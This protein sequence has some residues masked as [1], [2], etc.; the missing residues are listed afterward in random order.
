MRYSRVFASL[1][2]HL[3]GTASNMSRCSMVVAAVS[4]LLR[5]HVQSHIAYHAIVQHLHV[6]SNLWLTQ[7]K[8]ARLESLDLPLQ[9]CKDRLAVC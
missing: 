9:D 6:R 8:V 2:H 5:A 7:G 3:S 4:E 1:P